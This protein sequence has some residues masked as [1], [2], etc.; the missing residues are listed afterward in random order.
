[1]AN[2]H[3]DSDERRS[4]WKRITNLSEGATATIIAAAIAGLTTLIAAI[5]G[6]TIPTSLSSTK[7]APSHPFNY[8]PYLLGLIGVIAL[9]VLAVGFLAARAGIRR[10]ERRLDLIERLLIPDTLTA[11]DSFTNDAR[12]SYVATLGQFA[13]DVVELSKTVSRR[14]ASDV[15]TARQVRRAA[16]LLSVGSASRR[17][18]YMGSI[19]GVLL[20]AG[21]AELFALLAT[22]KP[23]PL[24]IGLTF[25]AS[26]AGAVLLAYQWFSG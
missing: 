3:R 15:V 10:R 4:I 24:E 5:I 13:R 6:A 22:A 2:V 12:N 1:M 9:V 14:E 26:M 18:N 19:G 8:L 17:G 25:A 20:G 23:S 11:S 16:E 21:L 7:P